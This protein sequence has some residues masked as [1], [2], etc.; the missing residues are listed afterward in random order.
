MHSLKS[1]SMENDPKSAL[2]VGLC[3]I[4]AV[5]LYPVFFLLGWC[6][7]S[8][9]YQKKASIDLFCALRDGAYSVFSGRIFKAMVLHHPCIG[10]G[11]EPKP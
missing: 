4:V 1:Q 2:C 8:P 10:P 6:T 3:L 7:F 11:D 5:L 9:I